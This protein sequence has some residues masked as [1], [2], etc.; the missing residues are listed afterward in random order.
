MHGGRRCRLVAYCSQQEVFF[1]S[2]WGQIVFSFIYFNLYVMLN[3]IFLCFVFVKC[4]QSVVFK[5]V[6]FLAVI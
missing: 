2:S 4:I 6:Y 5:L 3:A 1:Q